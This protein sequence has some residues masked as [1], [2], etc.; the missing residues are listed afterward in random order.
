M[1]KGILLWKPNKPDYTLVKAYRVISLLNYLGKVIEKIAAEAI[2]NYCETMRVL[3]LGQMGSHRH[4]SAIDAVACLI[5]KVHQ[6]WGQKQLAGALFMDVNEAF[7][8]VNPAK[9]VR[10]MGELGLDGDLIC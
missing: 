2:S 8:H 10:R 6:G 9:L 3:H 1:A 5:Q 7:D 4:Q